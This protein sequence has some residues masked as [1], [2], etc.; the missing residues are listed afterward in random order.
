MMDVVETP[1]APPQRR[2]LLLTHTGR[3]DAITAALQSAA[4]LSQAGITPVMLAE[5]IAVVRSTSSSED[6]AVFEPET[7]GLECTLGEI[8][9]GLVLGGDGSVLRAA[10][11][12]RGSAVPLMAVNLGHVGF[13]AE[14]ERTDL[15][16]TVQAIAENDFVVD[17]RTALDVVVYEDGCEVAR[18]W[19]LNEASVEKSNRERMLEV[20]VSVD[21]HA[22]SSYGCDGVVMA[23]PTGSTAYAFSAGGPVVWPGVEALLLVPISAHTLFSR[24]LVVGP[25]SRF[26]VDVLTRTNETGVLWCDGRRTVILPPAARVEVSRSAEPVRLARLSRTPFADRLVRKFKLP[27]QG[28]RGPVTGEERAEAAAARAVETVEPRHEAPRPHVIPPTTSAIPIVRAA[29]PASSSAR[30]TSDG[31]EVQP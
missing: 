24:P 2:V 22:L 7:L 15:S 30:Q 12:V 28:W 6:L 16:R 3:Q 8:H 18:T 10:E 29:R 17:E 25:F 26:A 9:L 19:A 27:T 14:S 23:T 11:L 20:V 1:S 4:M 5:D 21:D 31:T 13:L